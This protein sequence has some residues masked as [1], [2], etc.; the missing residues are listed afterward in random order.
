[1][2][3]EYQAPRDWTVQRSSRAGDSIVTLTSG[4]HL[5]R[6]RLLGGK[7]SKYLAPKNFLESFE[8]GTYGN[9]P[10]KK[11]TVVVA[12]ARRPL[13]VRSY[14]IRLGDPHVPTLKP[15]LAEE[16]FVIVPAQDG[17]YFVLSYAWE[18]PIPELGDEGEQAWTALLSSFRVKRAVK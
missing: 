17:K 6:V 14:A 16:R 9:G 8:A 5:L 7:D 4:A 13:Y 1:M 11:G 12:G 3:A 10:A 2:R 15:V 18:D